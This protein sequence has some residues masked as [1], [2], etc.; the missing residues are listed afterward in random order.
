MNVSVLKAA[1]L[2]ASGGSTIQVS[3]PGHVRSLLLDGSNPVLLIGAGASITSGIYAENGLLLSRLRAAS[4]A[5]STNTV[6][7]VSRS[8]HSGI[9]SNSAP[10]SGYWRRS[11]AHP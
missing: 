7:K 6:T 8:L 11:F 9:L 4:A 3:T 2:K 10:S 1:D 5:S